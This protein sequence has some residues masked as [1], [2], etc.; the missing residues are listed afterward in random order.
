MRGF[1]H[2]YRALVV[3]SLLLLI[4]GMIKVNTQAS[5][6]LG[7][8]TPPILE[9]QTPLEPLE[10]PSTIGYSSRYISGFGEGDSFTVFFEN[11]DALNEISYVSTTTG[12]LGFP[13]DVTATNIQDTHLLVKDWPYYYDG[14]WYDYR[15][16]GAVGNNPDHHFYV[17]DDLVNW[18]LVSTF[19]IPNAEGFD[20]GG[21]FVYYGF[22]DIIIINQTYYG[23]AEANGGETMLVRSSWGG[24]VWEAFAKVGGNQLEDGPLTT[25][26]SGIS[27]TPT[28]NFFELADDQGYG[29]LYVPGDDSGIYLAVNTVAKPSQ[30]PAVLESNFVDP[31][32]WTWHDGSTGRLTNDKALLY[33]TAV[34]DYR[35]VWMVPQLDPHHPWVILY[36]ADFDGKKALGYATFPGVCEPGKF[37]MLFPIILK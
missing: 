9:D 2:L 22:H 25:P 34:H 13:A 7:S 3:Q 15:A 24:D 26:D 37:C 5:P 8:I 17:S 20:A 21:S 10:N 35:E 30:E 31:G 4:S 19:T 6:Y 32:N 14:E 11:R 29:K 1:L 36:T 18:T 23:W 28:G 33:Q 16:W 27:P 12:P